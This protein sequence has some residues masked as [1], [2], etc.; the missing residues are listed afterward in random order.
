MIQKVKKVKKSPNCSNFT[1]CTVML[2]KQMKKLKSLPNKGIRLFSVSKRVFWQNLLLFSFLCK[3]LLLTYVN[4]M[5]E[6][7]ISNAKK[8]KEIALKYF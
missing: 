8:E 4:K 6:N 2:V 7:N 5:Y 3:L 1:Y